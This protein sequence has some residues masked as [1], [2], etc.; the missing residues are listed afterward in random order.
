M[1]IC[2]I[3]LVQNVLS[4]LIVLCRTIFNCLFHGIGTFVMLFSFRGKLLVIDPATVFV[5]YFSQHTY[6]H[7]HTHKN[8]LVY[9]T[10]PTTTP[11]SA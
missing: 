1:F 3:V 9:K 8:Y 6:S 2:A 7:T 11:P 5:E 10:Y 4:V